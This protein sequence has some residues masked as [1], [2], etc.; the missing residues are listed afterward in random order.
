M[1]RRE[2]NYGRFTA[3]A[4]G[5]V[6]IIAL[7]GAAQTPSTPIPVAGDGTKTSK[8]SA[9]EAPREK[10]ATATGPITVKRAVDDQAIQS[11][12]DHLLPRYPGVRSVRVTVDHGVV[13]LEGQVDQDETLDDITSFV[14]R[15][16]GVRLVLNRMKTDA[17]VLTARQFALRELHGYWSLFV[18][19]WVVG[20]MA[21]VVLFVFLFLA[22][23]FGRY[24]ETMLA[25]FVGNVLLRSVIG[26]FLSGFLIFLGVMA[27]LS[28]LNLTQM[29]L[30]IVGVAGAVG[31]AIGFAF[32]DIAENFISSVLL[33]VRRPFQIG[34]YVEVAGNAGVVRSLNT[35]ATVLVTLEGHAIRIPNS[36][37]F[38]EILIN[39]TATPSIQGTFEVLIPLTASTA[40]AIEAMNRALREQ[41]SI[42]PD[43]PA[44]TLVEALQPEGVRLK[45]YFWMPSKGADRFQIQSDAR[46]RAKVV[47]QQAG[48][49]PSEAPAAPRA[50]GT[51]A[52][53]E[54]SRRQ[55]KAN[56]RQDSEAAAA[57]SSASATDHPTPLQHVLSEARSCQVDEGENLLKD[58]DGKARQNG[59]TA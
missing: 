44:R 18:R 1:W 6:L 43:P 48:V 23:I 20:V 16:E 21:A 19:K 33:G 9:K 47:L 28:L 37:I 55:S 39:Y 3:T 41:E 57:A 58:H 32:R 40:A 2:S 50:A 29:V 11:T 22:R 12:L 24:S 25:P 38:K 46:L 53:A 10:V 42:L 26:S 45:A 35:R 51:P 59:K 27:A 14:E 56:L 30:S 4:C 17:D 13:T 52:Q 8:S 49:L 5:V 54:E 7:A 36:T 15:V 34:D 31:L